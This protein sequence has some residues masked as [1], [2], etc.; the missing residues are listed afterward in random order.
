MKL[1][2]FISET[3]N[4]VIEGVAQAQKACSASNAV[5]ADR[6][7]SVETTQVEFDVALT[8]E[9]GTKTKGG[10]GVVTGI[11][12]LGSSG[13]SDNTKTAVNRI[14]FS[15]PVVLPT[16]KSKRIS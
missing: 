12:S 5:I 14:K 13:Q 4:Q 11:V 16:D 9:S 15:V 3:L 1:D 7:G 6:S 8:V 2:E 10:I